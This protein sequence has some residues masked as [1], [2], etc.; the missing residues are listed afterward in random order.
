MQRAHTRAIRRERTFLREVIDTSPNPIF[1]KARDLTYSLA[2]RAA[3]AI[4]GLGPAQIVGRS[5][6]ELSGRVQRM[7]R[8]DAIDREILESGA[9]RIVPEEWVVDAAGDIRWFR[10]VKRPLRAPDGEVEQIVGTAVDV[11]DFKLAEQRLRRHEAELQA[12]REELRRLARQLIRAQEDERS[13]LAR[14]IH[15]DL[16]Q[17][18]AGLAMLTGSLARIA[19]ADPGNR[20]KPRL[21]EVRHELERLASDAQAIARDLHPSLLGNLGLEAA[22]RSECATFRER[23]GLRLHFESRRVPGDLLAEESLALYRI[24]QEALRNALTH[25]PGAEVVVTLE[26]GEQ[27]LTLRVADDGPGFEPAA[28]AGR[29]GLGLA[30]MAERARLIGGSFELDSAPGRGTRIA[31][32]VPPAG[33]AR[34][35]APAGRA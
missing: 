18:L 19:A 33:A 29:S 27:G 3:G 22:L 13:R 34:T 26:G 14:E 8:L 10:V 31:V 32:R 16:T 28:A 30:S 25:A 23:T 21:E 6:A 1:A 11:T 2:N 9:E 35:G 5:D 4:Y 12:S 15:D 20:L 17:R 24:A 7:D